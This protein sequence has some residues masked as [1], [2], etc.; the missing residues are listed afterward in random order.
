MNMKKIIAVLLCT[1][2]IT[3]TFTP[4]VNAESGNIDLYKVFSS[5]DASKTEVGSN[6]YKW[7]M[8]LPDDAIIYKSDRANYFNM[9]TTSY[10]STVSLEVNKNVNDSTLEDILY[11]I[12][13]QSKQGYYYLWGDKEFQVDI[14]RDGNGQKYLKIIK[15]GGYYDY[16]LVDEAAA[17]FREYIE[18]RI[19]IANGYLYNLTI[20]MNGEY[21][22]NHSDMFEKLTQ[23]FKLSFDEKNPN[24]KELSDSVSTKRDYINTSYGYKMVLSPY[25]KVSGTPNARNQLFQKVYTDEEMNRNMDTSTASEVQSFNTVAEGI[26]VSVV[27]SSQAGETSKL[28]ALK[29]V[30]KIKSNY[31][32]DVVELI[33]SKEYTQNGLDVYFVSLRFK[34]TTDKPYIMNNIYAIGNGYKYLVSAIMMDDKYLDNKKKASINDMLNS[35]SLDKSKLSQ[36][37]GKIIQAENLVSFT[38]SKDFKMQKYN[39]KTRLTRNW[40]TGN[41]Y[42]GGYGYGM[43]E[44][45]MIMYAAGYYGGTVSGNTE[46]IN[47]FEPDSNINLGMNVFL[48]S[49]KLDDVINPMGLNYLKNEEINLQLAKASITSAEY[50]G[51]QIYCISKEF[52]VNAI[53][54]FVQEDKTKSYNLDSIANEYQYIVKIGKDI[55]VQNISI[56]VSYTS[57]KNLKKVKDI[58]ANTTINNINYSKL[59]LQWKKHD[60][61]EYEPKQ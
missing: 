29:D 12:Q 20:S 17:E 35:F 45:T 58:W 4:I 40:S 57:E 53:Q 16:L 54:K 10:S 9:S 39:F 28:W 23:S 46:Y 13:N 32:K 11:S 21:F 6:I 42:Y 47:A 14:A 49:G 60:L 19:Y 38:E 22:K 30:D 24:I 34:T 7:S 56:P 27:G 25:W 18:N 43:Y 37:L 51:A 55:Y 52:D 44:K 8:Y 5:K 31:N 50:E 1:F 61:K 33:S 48:N 59:D 36:Y 26:T 3:A 2:I 15:A 41:N